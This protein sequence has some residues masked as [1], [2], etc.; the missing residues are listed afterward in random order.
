MKKREVLLPESSSDNAATKLH[1]ASVSLSLSLFLSLSLILF[2]L[3]R[4]PSYPAG[5]RRLLVRKEFLDLAS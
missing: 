4:I 5:R 3:I 1:R 2:D